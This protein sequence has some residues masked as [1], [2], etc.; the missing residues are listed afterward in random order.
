MFFDCNLCEWY[1]DYQ[2]A[3]LDA[4]ATQTLGHIERWLRPGV[5]YGHPQKSHSA[6]ARP[7][8]YRLSSTN[9]RSGRLALF[10]GKKANVL[11][12]LGLLCSW[13][14]IVIKWEGR[15]CHNKGLT[16]LVRVD[17][18]FRLLNPVQMQSIVKSGFY[19]CRFNLL[20][21]L[22]VEFVFDSQFIIPS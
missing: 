5:T 8:R 14:E 13:I 17:S 9:G 22:W 4:L 15:G 7:A 19:L 3:P 16:H 2:C 20:N 6:L 11:C 18:I 21:V 1:C 10:F 12:N